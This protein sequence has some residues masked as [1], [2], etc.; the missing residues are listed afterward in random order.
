MAHFNDGYTGHLYE[1]EVLGH[2]SAHHRGY[3]RWREA[4]EVVRKNQPRAH[5]PIAAKLE[6]AVACELRSSV[7]FFTAVR[8]TLD[9]MHGCDGFFEYSGVVVTIDLTLN[10][11]KDSGKADLIIAP[12]DVANVPALAERIARELRTKLLRRT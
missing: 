7:K 2:S 4:V 8:S 11:H 12:D 9:V 1:E 5:T 3:L 6:R 10:P